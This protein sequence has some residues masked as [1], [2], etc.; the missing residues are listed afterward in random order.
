[1]ISTLSRQGGLRYPQLGSTSSIYI[2][3]LSFGKAPAGIFSLGVDSG[4]YTAGG[5]D[6][7]LTFTPVGGAVTH[8]LMICGMGG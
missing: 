4:I 2:G 1:M 8:L 3:W 7:T 6:A 5:Q